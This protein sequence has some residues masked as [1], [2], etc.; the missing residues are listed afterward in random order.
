MLD[1]LAM[2]VAA[3][4]LWA[5]LKDSV[6]T[7]I[8]GSLGLVVIGCAAMV[9][10]DDNSFGNLDRVRAIVVALLVG[11]LLL[12]AQVVVLVVRARTGAT[13][14]RRRA[15]DIGQISAAASRRAR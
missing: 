8:L 7:G 11:V 15:T 14:P 10:V 3:L 13:T 6:P 4:A 1:M 9:A 12:A 2:S 5:I